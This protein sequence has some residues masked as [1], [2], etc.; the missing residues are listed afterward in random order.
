MDTISKS[1]LKANML[2]I[3]REIEASEEALIVAD[4]GRAVLRIQPIV[5]KMP[6]EEV[7]GDVSGGVVLFEDTNAPTI[8]EWEDA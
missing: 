4:R 6:I 5:E 3:F 2:R 7:F 8:D 1:K